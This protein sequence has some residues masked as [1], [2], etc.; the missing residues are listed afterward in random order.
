MMCYASGAL[1]GVYYAGVMRAL[2]EDGIGF[3]DIA[4]VSVG[5]NAAAWH[6]AGQTR[7]VMDAWDALCPYAVA[8]HP[9]MNNARTK[10]MDWLVENAALPHLDVEALRSSP[11]R[12]HVAVSLIRPVLCWHQGIFERRYFRFERDFDETML[13]NAIAASSFLP[14]INGVFASRSILGDHYH[15]G[16]ITGRVPLDCL[17]LNEFDEVWVAM[18]SEKAEA[19]LQ[20]FDFSVFDKTRFFFIRPSLPIA[21]GGVEIDHEKFHMVAEL[22]YGDAR[23]VVSRECGRQCCGAG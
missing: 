20:F 14:V 23:R 4:G 10:N 22:G 2:A 7:N 12:L 15:D 9:L 1:R 5:A 6:A 16:G 3:S 21:L 13:V 18:A 11:V 17:D 19:E 8:A